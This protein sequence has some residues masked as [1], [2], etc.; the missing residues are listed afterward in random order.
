METN[1][2]KIKI[3]KD[4]EISTTHDPLLEVKNLVKSYQELDVLKGINMSVKKKE[5][6]VIIGSSGGGKS[7]LLRCINALCSFDS[8]EIRLDGELI[9]YKKIN[10]KMIR[11]KEI[12]I[13]KQRVNVGMIFQNFNLFPHFTAINNII[14]APVRVKKVDKE[15]AY[16]E[17]K[18]LLK[19]I[20]L[21]SKA[22]VHPSRL[23]GGQQQRIAIARAIAMKPKLMLYDEVTSALD[24]ELIGEVLEV[25]KLIS[26]VGITSIVVTHE[27]SFAKEVA[28][29]IY[30]LDEG[31][32]IEYGPPNELLNNPSHKRTKEFINSVLK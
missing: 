3:F 14:E 20:G 24:P 4:Y 12:Q 8:G 22:D 9:G 31:K 30:F 21:E 25:M 13:S 16:Q 1:S 10:G 18:E 6:I 5:T 7:T 28:D 32:I 27:M 2:E 23:S 19:L 26:K 17:A 15:Q 11:L 29:L